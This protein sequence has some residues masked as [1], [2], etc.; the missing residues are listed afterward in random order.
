MSLFWWLKAV[1]LLSVRGSPTQKLFTKQKISEDDEIELTRGYRHAKDAL[2]VLE[3]RQLNPQPYSLSF[4][5]V[6][7]RSILPKD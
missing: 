7:F 5:N 2:K 1:N 3:E 6:I 4:D